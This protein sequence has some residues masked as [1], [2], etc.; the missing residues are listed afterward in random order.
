MFEIY[1]SRVLIADSLLF[2]LLRCRYESNTSLQRRTLISTI[3]RDQYNAKARLPAHHLRVRSRCF[4]ERDGLNHGGH[5]GQRTESERCITSSRGPRQGAFHLA[6][7]EY[8]IHARDLDRL[9]PDAEVNRYTARTK[10]LEGLGD[11]LASRSCYENDLGAAERLQ[12]RCGISSGTVNVV[13]SAELLGELRC[14]ATTGNRRHLEPHMP[15]VLHSQVTKAAD[16]EH[17]DKITGLCRRVSQGVK[18]RESGAQKG[19][20]TCR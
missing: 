14:V 16:T 17:S 13:V 4:L 19:R 10:A 5:A 8:E 15:G 3:L 18:R 1:S 2:P 11:R 20:R 7:S 6:I 9:R 12:S